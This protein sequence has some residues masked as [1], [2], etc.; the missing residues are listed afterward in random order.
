MVVWLFLSYERAPRD[1][2]SADVVQAVSRSW[3]RN[4]QVES[5]G[6]GRV[7]VKLHRDWL[8][9]TKKQFTK[10]G[11]VSQ[12]YYIPRCYFRTTATPYFARCLMPPAVRE[13]GLA[14]AADLPPAPAQSS[15]WGAIG[16]C[17]FEAVATAKLPG[18]PA[19]A[20]GLGAS[21]RRSSHQGS[22]AE[23]SSAV[24]PLLK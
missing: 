14:L 9:D 3:G 13:L 5:L 23:R 16:E 21:G 24:G 4:I 11:G 19:G 18:G 2:L 15:A 20:H 8:S 12:C 17:A 22:V 7:G 6:R 10:V 1:T